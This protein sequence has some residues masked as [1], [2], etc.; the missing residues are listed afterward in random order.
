[1]FIMMM[2]MMMMMMMVMVIVC[3]LTMNSCWRFESQ[4]FSWI[5]LE[6]Y[7]QMVIQLGS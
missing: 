2:M 1:M 7:L 4:T 5:C 3:C 6:V